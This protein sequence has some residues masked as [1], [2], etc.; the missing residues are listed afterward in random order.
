MIPDYLRK[1][2]DTLP[3]V[4]PPNGNPFEAKS[5]H[6]IRIGDPWADV[7]TPGH[8]WLNSSGTER[9]ALLT[10]PISEVSHAVRLTAAKDNG[11]VTLEFSGNLSVGMRGLVLR[12]IEANLKRL[13]DPALM[14]YLRSTED[15]N[16]VRR[17]RGIEV[18]G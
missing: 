12:Q 18:K 4:R 8:R 11:E 3:T 10:A 14:V 16:A 5:A 6:G 2:S 13:V 17:F 1:T 9:F 15:R 7:P